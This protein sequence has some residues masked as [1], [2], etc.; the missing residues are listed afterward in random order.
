MF[1]SPAL[2][3]RVSRWVAQHIPPSDPLLIAGDFNDWKQKATQ[4]FAQHLQLSEVFAH[5]DGSHAKTF[6]SF[7]PTLALDRIYFRNLVPHEALRLRG[8]PWSKLSD[9]IPLYAE[10]EIYL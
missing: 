4:E 6:P 8:E 3:D 2:L 1:G 10:V 7:W 5:I 9:H